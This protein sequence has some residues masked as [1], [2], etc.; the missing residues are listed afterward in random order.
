MDTL[1]PL[2][3]PG[4]LARVSRTR[5]IVASLRPVIFPKGFKILISPGCTFGRS[6]SSVDPEE[7]DRS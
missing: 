5:R 1:D 3:L 4:A 6:G 2:R 7:D